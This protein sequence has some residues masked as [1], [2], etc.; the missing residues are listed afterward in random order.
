MFKYFFVFA[1]LFAL[2]TVEAKGEGGTKVG[3]YFY[4][5]PRD[6]EHIYYC[7]GSKRYHSR[8]ERDRQVSDRAFRGCSKLV[9]S[10]LLKKNDKQ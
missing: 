6:H 2:I 4:V 10:N 8:V 1:I 9:T 3:G 7:L 5:S